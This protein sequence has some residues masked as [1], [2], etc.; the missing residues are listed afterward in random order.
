MIRRRAFFM[1]L[2]GAAAWP[3][4]AR[5]QQRIPVIAI[6]GS[7]AA[8]AGSS[9]MQVQLLDASM[10]ELGLVQGRDYVLEAR[11][12]GSDSSRFS[13]LAA[14][15]LALHP[16]AIV[17]FTNLA[18][19]TVQNLSHTVPIV[20]ASLNAPLA[21]GLVAS[22]AHPGGNITGV[23]TMADDLVLKQVEIM[24]EALP[25]ARKLA[26]MM[27]PTNPSNPLMLGMLT[28]RFASEEL[29]ISAVGVGAPADLDAA[30][31]ELSRQ[32]PDALFV[33]TDSSLVALA[34]TIVARA[35]AQQV[36]TFGS[37]TF[38]AAGAGALFNYSCDPKEASQGVARL[39]KKIL[40]GTAPGDPP[41]E[42][43]TKYILT[44]NLKTAKLLGITVPPS[45]LAI[46]DEVIE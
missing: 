33:L 21:T 45:L 25:Q 11:W 32:R 5:A 10:A 20:G 13:A 18:I 41:V 36:P 19:L 1:L 29:S 30:F 3:L 22:L 26:V 28:R 2:G 34:D 42:Q 44:L 6:L 27:N 35:L 4:A 7:G 8:D 43:P 23:S 17:A 12:A 24:H 15:L 37:L 39:L 16:S 38:T 14:E 9:T 40:N 31:A 46:A